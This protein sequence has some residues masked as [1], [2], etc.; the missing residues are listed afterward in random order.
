VPDALVVPASAVLTATDGTSTVMVVGP[1]QKAHQTA[2]KVGIRQD[3]NI[4]I[5]EGLKERQIVVSTGAYGLPDGTK[6]SVETAKD[7]EKDSEKG[8]DKP[9]AGEAKD[10]SKGDKE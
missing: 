4:Q 10:S 9:A 6:V 5:V 7:K 1:D 8:S 3:D 2:V